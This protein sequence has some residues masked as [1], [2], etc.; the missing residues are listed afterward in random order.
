MAQ[1]VKTN[2]LFTVIAF[3]FLTGLLLI[4]SPFIRDFIIE[5][6][7]SHYQ[8]EFDGLAPVEHDG[9]PGA[10]NPIA[11]IERPTMATVLRHAF[12]Q[13]DAPLTGAIAIPD[14]RFILPIIDGL[15]SEHLLYGATTLAKN[16]P[17][18]VGN[19]V[20]FGHHMAKDDL[21]FGPILQL[22]K[23]MDIFI[24]DK[25]HIYHYIVTD[26]AIVSENDTHFAAPTAEPILTLFTC[27][28]SKPT[29]KRFMAQATL[30]SQ[31]NYIDGAEQFAK[32]NGS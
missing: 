16:Q 6:S 4:A 11:E 32:K 3:L 24:T 12:S 1:R 9:P 27:D 28:I 25:S 17:M 5:R 30:K 18:G 14:I 19:Y 8:D 22:E 26:T 10:A 7:I 2:I 29:N 15:T 13:N 21:L 31:T 23:D 20:L